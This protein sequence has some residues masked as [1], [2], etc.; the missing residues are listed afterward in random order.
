MNSLRLLFPTLALLLVLSAPTMAQR[1]PVGRDT[2]RTTCVRGQK[3]ASFV[4]KDGD[5]IN[6]NRC[7]GMG[8]KRKGHHGKKQ[9]R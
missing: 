6:D 3:C 1:E 9:C 7:R 8:L 2:T 4:D 5:G